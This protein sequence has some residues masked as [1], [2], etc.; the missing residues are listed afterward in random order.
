DPAIVALA[1]R[2]DYAE[3]PESAYPKYYSGSLVVNTHDGRRL[4]H[5]EAVNRGADANPLS[6]SDILEKYFDNTRLALKP[7]AAE[8]LA[9][10]VLCLESAPDLQELA[11]ALTA[12]E[13]APHKQV[14]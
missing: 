4:E 1:A 11:A 3:D 14:V 2:I 5:R 7:S 9:D 8:R 6:E 12:V 10:I 13:S